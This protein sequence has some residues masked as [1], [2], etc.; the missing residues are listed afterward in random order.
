MIPRAR[1]PPYDCSHTN[2]A[3]F[4][5]VIP[6]REYPWSAFYLDRLQ[7]WL[8]GTKRDQVEKREE[9]PAVAAE[10]RLYGLLSCKTACFPPKP[11]ES[12]E[13]TYG[14]RG[15]KSASICEGS[16]TGAAAAIDRDFEGRIPFARD[17]FMDEKSSNL[18]RIFVT[19]M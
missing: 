5:L 19:P 16:L 1:L 3:K 13:R 7:T 17:N 14:L 9:V 18:A 6:G 12:G 11:P 2:P 10:R 15:G 8:G 4:R